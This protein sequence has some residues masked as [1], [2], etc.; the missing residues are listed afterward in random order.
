MD[1]AG[2]FDV[3][4]SGFM[5][6]LFAMSACACLIA[7]CACLCAESTEKLPYQRLESE[8]SSRESSGRHTRERRPSHERPRE[9]SNSPQYSPLGLRPAVSVSAAPPPLQIPAPAA[10]PPPV[11]MPQLQIP[12]LPVLE[13]TADRDAAEVE[14]LRE[15][16]RS[17]YC[18]YGPEMELLEQTVAR[19]EAE[20][21]AATRQPAPRGS[22]PEP[23]ARR[24]ATRVRRS[25]VAPR[26]HR[27]GARPKARP[28][29]NRQR[30]ARARRR[31]SGD[32]FRVS[33]RSQNH[34][35]FTR[36]PPFCHA[37]FTQPARLAAA[38]PLKSRL[39][40]LSCPHTLL[41]HLSA[42][43]T[44]HLSHPSRDGVFFS[45]YCQ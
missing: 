3:A 5:L 25:R 31:S 34:P 12:V 8:S 26:Q 20:A 10:K 9:S 19:E 17:G 21:E 16:I 41:N 23:G 40:T 1:F 35:Q 43:T 33:N 4:F 22:K 32:F 30:R 11:P 7:G 29:P 44:S 6:L 36:N 27:P 28:S 2:L 24:P 37:T 42:H 15:R 13:A 39:Q 18:L 45:Y 14:R 38:R